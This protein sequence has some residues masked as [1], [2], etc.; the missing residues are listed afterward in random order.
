MWKRDEIIRA[1]SRDGLEP[2]PREELP[3]MDSQHSPPS[4]LYIPP[5]MQLRHRCPS[6][7]R[8]VVVRPIQVTM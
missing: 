3:C 1:T 7:G 5:G 6:C 2:I 8:E 4:H